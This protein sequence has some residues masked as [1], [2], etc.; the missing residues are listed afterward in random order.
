M[1]ET[2]K[3]GVCDSLGCDYDKCQWRDDGYGGGGDIEE[4]SSGKY[5]TGGDSGGYSGGYS[6]GGYNS[7]REYKT[8]EEIVKEKRTDKYAGGE[9]IEE[10]KEEERVEEYEEEEE[11]DYD[12]DDEEEDEVEVEEVVKEDEEEIV[13]PSFISSKVEVHTETTEESY[14]SACDEVSFYSF[15]DISKK[16]CQHASTLV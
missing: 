12:D 1:S 7:I 8:G 16:N 15:Y 10:Y 13:A 5:Y 14:E 4:V 9:P 3:R 6:G 2:T 11:E